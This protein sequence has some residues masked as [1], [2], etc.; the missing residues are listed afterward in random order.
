MKHTKYG[1]ICSTEIQIDSDLEKWLKKTKSKK[2]KRSR[3]HVKGH[4][5]FNTQVRHY[6][7][8]A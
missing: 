8:K 6:E 4:G 1:Y 3:D 2:H 7:H 5:S